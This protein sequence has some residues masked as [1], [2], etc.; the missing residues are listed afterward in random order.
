MPERPY[1]L[2][3]NTD[4]E[5]ARI[6]DEMWEVG[7][8]RVGSILNSE[9]AGLLKNTFGSMMGDC[10][11][12]SE[13]WTEFG[14]TQYLLP[15][16][17]DRDQ[18]MFSNIAGRDKKAD[19]LLEKIMTDRLV[20]GA[21]TLLLGEGYKAWELSARRSNAVDRGLRLHEDAIGEFGISVL[22]NDQ[23]DAYG[24]TALVPRSHR[25]KVRC[26]EAG[27]EDYLRP[28][29]MR[30]FTDPVIG[31]AG[32]VYF[33]FKKTWHGRIKSIKNVSSDSLIF[34]LYPSGYRFKPFDIPMAYMN[35]LPDEL[36]RLLRTDEGL[37][38]QN[39]GYFIVQGDVRNDRI[40]DLIYRKEYSVS[41]VWGL[42]PYIKPSLDRARSVYL[43]LRN[44][45]RQ[46]EAHT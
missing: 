16:F 34:G 20:K 5:V 29:F 11:P 9:E 43:G 6:C 35:E 39:D 1:D 46:V 10:R 41:S 24:T 32:D 45:F 13:R 27:V 44:Y 31:S 19:L 42:G 26:R 40:I 2:P 25:S 15:P 38:A 7:Y 3:L 36:K 21:L 17:G 18:I 23:Y 28:S 30:R 14:A 12:W 8:S 33:F 22:L 4:P 37:V